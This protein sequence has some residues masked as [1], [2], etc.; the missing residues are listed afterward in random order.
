MAWGTSEREAPYL[1]P[2]DATP[3]AAGMVVMVG[4]Y[5]AGQKVS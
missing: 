4:V 5:T 2:S 3:L 1:D